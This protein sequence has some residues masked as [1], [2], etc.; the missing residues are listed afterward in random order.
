MGTP[1][2]FEIEF[3]LQKLQSYVSGLLS[4]DGQCD[5]ISS[6]KKGVY[7]TDRVGTS[8]PASEKTQARDQ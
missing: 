3:Q 4:Q 6:E 7:K 1:I 8:F 5:D 2:Q